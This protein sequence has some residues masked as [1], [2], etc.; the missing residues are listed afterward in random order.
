MPPLA[1]ERLGSL[2]R[3]AGRVTLLV[4][5]EPSR[6][7]RRLR[8]PRVT[9]LGVGVAQWREPLIP[10]TAPGLHVAGDSS[11]RLARNGH[12]RI[13]LYTLGPGT[14]IVLGIDRAR[15]AQL[16]FIVGPVSRA[17]PLGC[18]AG[19]LVSAVIATFL[20]QLM[21]VHLFK[22][23]ASSSTRISSAV[24]LICRLGAHDV[25]VGHSSPAHGRGVNARAVAPLQSAQTTARVLLCS[26]PTLSPAPPSST[27]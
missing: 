17:Q 13:M 3:R 16:D 27:W 22:E 9:G 6:R 24:H 10:S 12:G 15:R 1:C 11:A 18:P 4:R 20:Q 23:F 5:L 7:C 14:S 8:R 25:L 21:S 26:A 2:I 19:V